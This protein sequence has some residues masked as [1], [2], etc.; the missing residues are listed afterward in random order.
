MDGQP[1]PRG[2]EFT[3]S[4]RDRRPP[5]EETPRADAR[6]QTPLPVPPTSPRR[7][8]PP[9]PSWIKVRF[10]ENERY[11]FLRERL[12]R[13]SLH[14]VCEEADCPNMGECWGH[15]TA[16][17]LLM[18]EICTR[19]C[20]FCSVL[21]GRPP[22]LD[23]L[24]PEKVAAVVQDLQLDYAVLTSVDRDD[25][26]DE[27]AGHFARTIEAIRRLS[28]R[29]R[30]EALVPD[31]HARPELIERLVRSPLVVFAH[32][33]ETV[34]RLYRRVRPG[35]DYRRSLET[36]RLARGISG[37]IPGRGSLLTKSSLMVGLGE[38]RQE[39]LGVFGDLRE[40]RVDILTLGQY[41]Q[42]TARQ[43]EVFR[44]VP[45]DEFEDL[46]REALAL[47]FSQVVA[48]PLVRSSYHAW[49]AVDGIEGGDAGAGDR[50]G[51]RGARGPGAAPPA[52]ARGQRA[53]Q[54]PGCGPAPPVHPR[55]LNLADEA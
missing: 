18:G 53:G 41:L 51:V 25:L 44:H 19:T 37:E 2:A 3:H 1:D 28:P 52:A 49:E 20:R 24:E 16:T 55:D 45:P 42:P 5:A 4:S 14:T 36:L 8:G 38:S 30:V 23:P 12:R 7:G 32:N 39:L 33:V 10:R 13:H 46:R 54:P 6:R 47:G 27:G 34:P 40:Q 17:F 22:P 48:G 9:H 43:V 15:G 31:F 35:S 50:P 26:P 11:R 29:C 21:K